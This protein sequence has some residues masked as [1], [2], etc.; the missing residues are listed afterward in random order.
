[1]GWGGGGGGRLPRD[2]AID[3]VEHGEPVVGGDLPE[4][5]LFHLLV[6]A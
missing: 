2:S 5:R 1:M 6:L 3:D 4:P